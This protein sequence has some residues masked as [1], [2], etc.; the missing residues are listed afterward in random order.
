M[1]AVH[2]FTRCC[3]E[4]SALFVGAV[5]KE[6]DEQ[7][8]GV[9]EEAAIA[10]FVGQK[11]ATLD[12]TQSLE[13]VT[14]LIDVIGNRRILEIGT[15]FNEEQEENAVHVAQTLDRQFVRKICISLDRLL[16]LAGSLNDFIGSFIAQKFNCSAKGLL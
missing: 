5:R 2:D 7:I 1:H 15:G 12:L 14:A 9:V 3:R 6:G 10:V 13:G 4:T 11:R 16:L 8:N